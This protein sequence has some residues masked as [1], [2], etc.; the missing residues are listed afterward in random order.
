MWIPSGAP[1]EQRHEAAGP[2]CTG[3]VPW[4]CLKPTIVEAM[5]RGAEGQCEPTLKWT[6]KSGSNGNFCAMSTLPQSKGRL[7][8]GNNYPKPCINAERGEANDDLRVSDRANK[9]L[10]LS[11][12]NRPLSKAL[13]LAPFPRAVEK[14]KGTMPDQV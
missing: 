6:P 11:S 12:S 14:R 5:V 3:S 1:E 8:G 9:W 7:T 10:S 2:A 13:K 4:G